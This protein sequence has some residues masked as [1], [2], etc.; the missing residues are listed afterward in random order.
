MN[1]RKNVNMKI[2]SYA[3]CTPSPTSLPNSLLLFCFPLISTLIQTTTSSDAFHLRK[4]SAPA[5]LHLTKATMPTGEIVEE[6]VDHQ[7]GLLV[8][9]GRRRSN[10]ERHGWW[11]WWCGAV[12]GGGRSS[13][14]GGLEVRGGVVE[15]VGDGVWA[16]GG[17][18]LEAI[19]GNLVVSLSKSFK[20]LFRW[21]GR[22]A[23]KHVSWA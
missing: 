8:G 10:D 14:D 9:R 3:I 21:L 4:F 16:E 20:R 22:K 19:Y 5:F 23:C 12:S 7:W 18:C 1:Y 6:L 17:G 11:S 2:F 15:A 13:D